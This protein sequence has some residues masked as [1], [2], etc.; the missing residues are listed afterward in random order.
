MV[1]FHTS[2]YTLTRT[3]RWGLKALTFSALPVQ[4]MA[5]VAGTEDV[6]GIRNEEDVGGPEDQ[7][8]HY[9]TSTSV[10]QCWSVA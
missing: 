7:M 1:T 9:T 10:A 4:A 8:G 2:N 6:D 5:R 3:P